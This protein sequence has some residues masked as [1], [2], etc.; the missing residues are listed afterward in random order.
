[1]KNGFLVNCKK[2]LN[3]ERK[4][5]IFHEVYSMYLLTTSGGRFVVF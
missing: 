4:T 3:L 5:K 2:F 1:M